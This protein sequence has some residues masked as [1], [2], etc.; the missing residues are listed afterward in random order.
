MSKYEPIEYQ[1]TCSTCKYLDQSV[2]LTSYPPQAYCTYF[3]K[4]VF[5]TSTKCLDDTEGDTE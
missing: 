5:V 3:N 2:I 4:P 1:Q